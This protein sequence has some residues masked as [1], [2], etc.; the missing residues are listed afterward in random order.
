MNQADEVEI[1][2][3]GRE[4]AADSVRGEEESA[5]EHGLENASEAP[6]HYNDF[7]ANGNDPLNSVSQPRGALQFHS[8]LGTQNW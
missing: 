7:S 5:I 8:L 1:I 2:G 4:L 3:H 6:R